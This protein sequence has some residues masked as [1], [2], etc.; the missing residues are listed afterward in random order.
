MENQSKDCTSMKNYLTQKFRGILLTSILFTMFFGWKI[1]P[2]IDISI[3]INIPVLIYLLSNQSLPNTIKE[4]N[5]VTSILLITIIYLSIIYLTNNTASMQWILR[6]IRGTLSFITI[7]LLLKNEKKSKEEEYKDKFLLYTSLAIS[8][9]ATIIIASQLSPDIRQAL[10]E[11]T[12]ASLYV[13]EYVIR[14][15]IQS[16][17]LTYSLSLTSFLYVIS[18]SI[19][20]YVKNIKSWIKIT[21]IIVNIIACAW[22]ART[23]IALLPIA[24]LAGALTSISMDWRALSKAVGVATLSCGLFVAA[25][26]LGPTTIT[27]QIDRITE[28]FYFISNP[29][30]TPFGREFLPMF[31][32]PA[33]LYQALFGNSLTGREKD[34]YVSS[35]VGYILV[36]Y[37]T[38]FTGLLLMLAPVVLGI[39]ISIKQKK[40]DKNYSI[41]S[42]IILLG[43]LLLNLKELALMTRTVWPVICVIISISLLEYQ[44]H[45]RRED[46]VENP[47]QAA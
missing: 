42:T 8:I 16:L 26:A 35:D 18:V 2:I 44:A 12:N 43:Y 38:G 32:L 39:Y 19:L 17:G 41:L 23:G 3:I 6:T 29:S 7:I 10:H 36:I 22:T 28:I 33:D 14:S 20:I 46:E 47:Q 5:I 25:T 9:H 31:H 4:I 24:L 11:L 30:S 13:N 27:L 40:N 15:N 21:L 37:G 34:Y 1:T 45:K